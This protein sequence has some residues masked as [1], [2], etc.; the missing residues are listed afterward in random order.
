MRKFFRK[1]SALKARDNRL[2][3]HEKGAREAAL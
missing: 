3:E 2:R 1:S